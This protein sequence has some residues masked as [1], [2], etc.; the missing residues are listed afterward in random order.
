MRNVLF[1]ISGPSGVGKG[2]LV[3]Q[4][5]RRDKTLTLSVSCTT[6]NPREGE[7]NGRDYF[8]LTREEFSARLEAD[9]FLEYDEHF[10][11]LYGT[12]KSFVWE[13]L[14]SR[15]VILEI[16][17]EGALKVAQTM[18]TL[19]DH[20][21]LVLIMVVP[22][23]L[24]ALQSR[25]G[26]RGSESKEELEK[27]LARVRYELSKQPEYDYIVVND[28]LQEAVSRLREIIDKERNK[29]SRNDQ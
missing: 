28:V 18:R 26:K 17:V 6:R 5:L 19:K 24:E 29:E 20:P 23:S 8:F 25:L 14:E 27:R 12:P 13:Q 15:S 3:K 10:E 11:N 21:P 2:T 22:P 1:I 7:R 4:V 9:D 16:D